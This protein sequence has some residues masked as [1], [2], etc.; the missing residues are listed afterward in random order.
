MF[1]RKFIAAA[2][3]SIPISGMISVSEVQAKINLSEGLC[4]YILN[5]SSKTTQS[6]KFHYPKNKY[7]SKISV[8]I[9]SSN[10]LNF[11]DD[12]QLI[13]GFNRCGECFT[14]NKNSGTS[15]GI[16]VGSYCVPCYR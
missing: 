1:Q 15:P 9:M 5:I 6:I 13:K 8:P 11:T 4:K 10:T 7:R 16:I 14:R 12:K 2:L 3:L